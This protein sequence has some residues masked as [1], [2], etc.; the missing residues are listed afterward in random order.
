MTAGAIAW[1]A[2]V[3]NIVDPSG[4]DLA[5]KSAPITPFAPDLFSTI[6]D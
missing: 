5:T 1:E 2:I 3:S 6:I 4:A